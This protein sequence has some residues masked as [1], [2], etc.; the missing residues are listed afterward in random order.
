VYVV[1]N[2]RLPDGVKVAV[3]LVPLYDTVPPIL[4]PPSLTVNVDVPMVAA[5]IASLNVAVITLFTA[6][7]VALLIG[8]VAFTTG[9]VVSDA[10]P[11]VKFHT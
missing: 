5:S 4:P 2:D 6:T 11:V 9:G 1:E 3:V 7:F 10:T 8:L